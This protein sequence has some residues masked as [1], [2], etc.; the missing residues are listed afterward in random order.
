MPPMGWNMVGC[1]SKTS[2]TS[3][4]CHRSASSNSFIASGGVDDR[5]LLGGAGRNF[6][7]GAIGAAEEQIGIEIAVLA[8][9]LDHALA[10]AGGDLLVERALLDALG[11]QLADMAARVVD[12]AALG[13]ATPPFSLSLCISA[14]RE[15][16]TSTSSATPSSRQ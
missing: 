6:V 10:I 13:T 15:E 16:F 11:E 5:R 7:A 12:D 8:Q 1:H 14:L 9:K 2:S 3:M 4:P